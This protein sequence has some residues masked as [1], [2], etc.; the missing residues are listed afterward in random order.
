MLVAQ[1]TR[2]GEG[3]W[4]LSCLGCVEVS[5]SEPHEVIELAATTGWRQCN[6]GKQHCRCRS[7]R[8]A[9]LEACTVLTAFTK[10]GPWEFDMQD[11][12]HLSERVWY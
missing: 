1:L 2:D 6:C 4:H 12:P 9:Y 7:T 5:V 3:C 10:R 8:D 11:T